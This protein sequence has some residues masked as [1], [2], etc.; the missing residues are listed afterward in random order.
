MVCFVGLSACASMNG[1][2]G[3]NFG[4]SLESNKRAQIIDNS[5][6]SSEQPYQTGSQAADAIERHDARESTDGGDSAESGGMA[7]LGIK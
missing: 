5:Q 2:I 4:L 6:P 7:P 3:D 1:P